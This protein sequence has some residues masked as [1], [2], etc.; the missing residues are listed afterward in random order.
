MLLIAPGDQAAPLADSQEPDEGEHAGGDEAAAFVPTVLDG[1]QVQWLL[2]PDQADTRASF[3][4][5]AVLL[6]NYLAGKLG[7][8]G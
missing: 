8:T 3:N 5:F 2:D 4:L 7:P 6:P 1:L